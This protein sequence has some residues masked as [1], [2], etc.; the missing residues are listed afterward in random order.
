MR[1]WIVIAVCL[2]GAFVV[3]AYFYHGQ[4]FD[5]LQQMFQ[6]IAHHFQR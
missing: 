6:R 4:Y 2:I 1:F 3:D 5:A